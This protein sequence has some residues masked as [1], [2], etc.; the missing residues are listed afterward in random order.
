MRPDVTF[1]FRRIQNRKEKSV[2]RKTLLDYTIE[3]FEKHTSRSRLLRC[4]SHFQILYIYIYKYSLRAVIQE[5]AINHVYSYLFESEE[6]S[7]YDGVKKKKNAIEQTS[8]LT[9][10]YGHT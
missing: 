3:Y 4:E 1:V 9:F 10:R 7:I 8:I 6:K 2:D 5:L